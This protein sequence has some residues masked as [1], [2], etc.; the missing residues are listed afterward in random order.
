[1]SIPHA[2]WVAMDMP[3]EAFESG[4]DDLH[5]APGLEREQTQ[6]DVHRDVFAGTEGTTHPGEVDA[7]LVFG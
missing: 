3:E 2:S 7:D 1:V 4:V 6:V 5:G